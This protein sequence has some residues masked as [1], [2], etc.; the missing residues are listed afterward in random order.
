MHTKGADGSLD[1]G[2]VRSEVDTFERCLQGKND[3]T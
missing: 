2:V 3:R 1:Q